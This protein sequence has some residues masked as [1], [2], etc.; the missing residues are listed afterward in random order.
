MDFIFQTPTPNIDSSR[1]FYTKLG[2]NISDNELGFLAYDTQIVVQV[3]SQRT[4]RAGL[5]C[6]TDKRSELV[7]RLKE[8]FPVLET[9]AEAICIAPCGMSIS[10]REEQ[11]PILSQ[12]NLTPCVMGNAAGL[13]LETLD[14]KNHL[15]LF[16]CLGFDTTKAK[17]S[18][19][20]IALSHPSGFGLSLLKTGMCPHLFFNPSI[21]FFNGKEGNPKVISELRRLAIALAEEISHFNTEG[22]VDNV[23]VRDPGGFG[24]FIFND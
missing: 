14:M 24:F 22:I 2:F 6:F 19:A 20:W 1:D 17:D 21:S 4:S 23:I 7:E 15:V 11:K 10:I 9:E 16:N 18:D 3:N 12:E 13:T 5:I 8:Q